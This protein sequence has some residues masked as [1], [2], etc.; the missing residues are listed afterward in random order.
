MDAGGATS[1]GHSRHRLTLP[2]W[3]SSISVTTPFPESVSAP[4]PSHNSTKNLSGNPSKY[5]ASGPASCYKLQ[6]DRG[7]LLQELQKKF[8]ETKPRS[9]V[10]LIR[11]FVESMSSWLDTLANKREELRA[12]LEML[13]KRFRKGRS[14]GGKLNKRKLQDLHRLSQ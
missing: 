6:I 3:T 1:N 12:I 9:R 10:K 7:Y 2:E 5:S 8:P 4:Y 13:E 11:D 14:R